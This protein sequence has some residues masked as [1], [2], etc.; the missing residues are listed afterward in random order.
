MLLAFSHVSRWGDKDCAA[1]CAGD[2][3]D[4]VDYDGDEGHEKAE[5]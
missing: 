3:S 4:R 2:G 5:P 1:D